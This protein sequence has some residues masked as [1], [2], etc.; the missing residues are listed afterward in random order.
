[1]NGF[2][3]LIVNLVNQKKYVGQTSKSVA[4]RW[5]DHVANAK[6]GLDFALYRAIRKY[7]ASNFSIQE[8]ACCEV[9]LLNDLEKQFIKSQGT[10]ASLGSGYN[11][12]LG[13]EG[14]SGWKMPREVVER[15]RRANIG[16]KRTKEFC[17][18]QSALKKGRV[19]HPLALATLQ[20]FA[21]GRLGKKRS[22][23]ECAAISA[24]K[25]RKLAEVAY[26]V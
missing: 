20:S 13:G 7:G 18:S 16:K 22:P 25:R 8:L 17:D 23:E 24:G 5:K 1:M 15:I 14:K 10:L 3:Y 19:P 21:R 4:G 2:I 9:S 11:E 26:P 12:T 6:S